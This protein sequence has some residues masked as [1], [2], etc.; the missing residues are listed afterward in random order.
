M[1]SGS[2]RTPLPQKLPRS[3]YARPALRVARD[4]LGKYLVRKSGRHLLVG[5]IV[6]VEAYQGSLDPASHAY[7]GKTARNAV[8]FGEAGYLYVYFT[9]GMHY[10]A[11]VVSESPGKAGA[12]LLRALEP[13]HGASQMIRNRKRNGGKANEALLTRGPARLCQAFRIERRENGTDLLGDEIFITEGEAVPRSLVVRSPR[14]G[15]RVAKEKKWRFSLKGNRWV[16][17]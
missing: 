12:V 11:N 4:L 14:I 15:I 1:N 2:S 6:E 8:M 9:Y 13:I 16:S 10:C 7:R 5:K 17:A 3:F